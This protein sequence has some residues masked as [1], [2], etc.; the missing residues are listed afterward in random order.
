MVVTSYVPVVEASVVCVKPDGKTSCG[1]LH[2]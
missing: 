2:L 1:W